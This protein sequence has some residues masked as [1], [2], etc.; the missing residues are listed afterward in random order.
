M[1]PIRSYP[2]GGEYSDRPEK[3]IFA[4]DAGKMTDKR[5]QNVWSKAFKEAS[6][7]EKDRMMDLS[8]NPISE[9]TWDSQ[10]G[11]EQ[12]DPNQLAMDDIVQKYLNDRA[13]NRTKKVAMGAAPS[14]LGAAAYG[15]GLQPRYVEGPAGSTEPTRLNN[16]QRLWRMLGMGPYTNAEPQ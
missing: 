10:G 4:R 12:V 16:M 3:H 14:L 6:T 15:T 1:R 2:Y 13:S 9:S 8:L 11:D 5:F 7:E